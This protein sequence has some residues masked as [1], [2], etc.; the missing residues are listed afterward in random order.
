MEFQVRYL[1]L[2]LLLS[3]IGCLSPVTYIQVVLDGESLQEDPVNAGVPQGSILGP[4]FFVLYIN[5][6]LDDVICNIGIY[7]DDTLC[8]ECDQA[9]DLWQQL[10]LT[11]AGSGLLISVMEKHNWFCLTGLIT[12]VLLM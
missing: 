12:V 8:S 1:A 7:T 3:V 4:T 5:D 2:F 9:S 11:E 6:L 10:E